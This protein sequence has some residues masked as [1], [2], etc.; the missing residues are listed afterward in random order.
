MILE[1]VRT[2]LLADTDV[3]DALA[4]YDF[5]DGGSP[6]IFTTDPIPEDSGLPAIVLT[7][8]EGIPWGTRSQRGAEADVYARMYDNKTQSS[9][10]VRNLAWDVR[11]AIERAALTLDGYEEVGVYADTPMISPDPEGFP[12]YRLRITVRILEDE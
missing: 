5:G 7:M 3:T 8:Q 6:A 4:E 1:A 10:R 9:E 11:E 2:V 12:G